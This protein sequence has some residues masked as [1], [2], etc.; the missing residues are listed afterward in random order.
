M[1]LKN[2]GSMVFGLNH[3]NKD[4][5]TNSSGYNFG[6]FQH[7]EISAKV[8]KHPDKTIEIELIGPFDKNFVFRR[9]IPPCDDR[10]LHVAIT[11][12]DDMV[13]LYLNGEL[14][15]SKTINESV[16]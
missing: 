4:W 13:Q 7:E 15:D 6:S 1:G 14:D 10:G 9:P 5:S 3:E 2:E 8:T 12:K 11:W 16:E